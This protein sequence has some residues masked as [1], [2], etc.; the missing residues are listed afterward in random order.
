MTGA[1]KPALRGKPSGVRKWLYRLAAMTLVPG[2]LFAILEVSL[3]LGGYGYTT[4]Y[5]LDGTKAEGRDVWIDNSHFDRWVFPAELE[6]TS[7]PTPF[8][9]AKRKPRGTFRIFVMGESAAWGFPD[10]SASFSRVLEV[11]L[12]ARYPD[13]RFEVVNT[14]M[15][16]INSHV[17]FPIAR[18]CLKKQPDLLIIHLGNNEVVG[19]YGAAGVLGS[20][21]PRLGLIRANLAVK[22]TRTGQLL[23]GLLCGLGNKKEVPQAWNGMA[24]FVHSRIAEQDE[25]LKRIYHHYRKNLEAICTSASDAGVPAVVCTVGVNLKDS[26]PFA[27]LHAVDLEAEQ[28]EAWEKDYG[29]GVRLEEQKRFA[30]ALGRY[31]DAARID[32]AFADLAFRRGR[33]LLALG[34]TSAARE[35]FVRAWD[36]D[37]LRFRSDATINATIR[38]VVAA[39]ADAGI[40]LADVERAF[41][42]SSPDGIPGENLFLEHVHMNFHG[43]YVLARTVFESIKE[44]APAGLGT[45]SGEKGAPLSEKECA[46][47]LEYTSWNELKTV[48]TIK[49][50]VTVQ[51]PFTLQLDHAERARRWLAKLEMVRAREQSDGVQKAVGTHARAMADAK[52]DWMIPMN[53]GDYLLEHNDLSNAETAYRTA[54]GRM[55]HGIQI[56]CKLGELYLRGGNPDAA[57]RPFREALR[58]EPESLDAHFGLARAY[59]AQG[60]TGAALAVYE[61]RARKGPNRFVATMQL[62][63]FLAGTGKLEQARERYQEAQRMAPDNWGPLL[64]L[65]QVAVKQEKLDEAIG[66]YESM[67]RVWP[68]WP[69]VR[70]WV[71]ELRKRKKNGKGA[72]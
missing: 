19:P 61:E 21:S 47:R 51:P 4:A 58:L 14:A 28:L 63:D 31:E 3:R 62:A 30:E 27:S 64:G 37:A 54:L 60:K 72:R 57:I 41:E 36:L 29:E 66:H 55:R 18:E 25:R 5:F 32:D 11:M 69:E 26:A 44:L 50:M 13:T 24:M 35:Q 48:D 23:G 16:A 15:V 10:P 65:A 33:C 53:Y 34:K 71:E 12:R 56:R 43:N 52:E 59:A 1:S 22:T 7:R 20:F 68:E 8:A 2:L 40:V 70:A 38:D 6:G 46:E 67:L 39:Q 49:S 42:L 45:R 9:F 17:V